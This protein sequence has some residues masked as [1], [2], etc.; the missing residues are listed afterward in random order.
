MDEV[1]ELKSIYGPVLEASE[2]G[3][4]YLLL[5]QLT[6]PDGCLPARVDSLLCPHPQDGYSSRLFFAEK[7]G[8]PS[9]P[10]WNGQA[11]LLE[12]NWFAFSWRINSPSPLRLA[13]MV[14]GHLRGLR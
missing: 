9:S 7:P 2:G 6:L 11:R 8:C 5:P 10:K 4:S 12:R 13:Q 14:Q 1:E 3:N